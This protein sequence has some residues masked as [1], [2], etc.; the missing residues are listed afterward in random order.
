MQ[1]KQTVLS[2]VV[3]V[4]VLC[5][6]AI[7]LVQFLSLSFSYRYGVGKWIRKPECRNINRTWCDLSSETSDY[8]EQYYASV[9]AF[10]NGMCSDWVETTR[11][12][13][14]TDSKES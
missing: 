13:P 2:S 14:L 7:A 1:N 5:I 10:L 6:I 4:S 3:S 8:E 12:N 11:F 9:K